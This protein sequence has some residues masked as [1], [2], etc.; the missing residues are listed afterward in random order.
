MP[1]RHATIAEKR[2]CCVC[3][4]RTH[5]KGTRGINNRPRDPITVIAM[6]EKREVRRVMDCW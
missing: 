2:R 4:V 3:P 6:G 1:C 5:P